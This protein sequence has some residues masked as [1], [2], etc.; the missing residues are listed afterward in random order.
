[1]SA[2]VEEIIKG[3]LVR[4]EKAFELLYKTY[5]RTLFGIALR[6]SRNREEAEDILQDAFIKIFHSI[7]S[8]SMQ[9]SFEGWLKRIVQNT[10]INNYRS[11]LK[12]D[13]HIDV[14]E[15]E[16][17]AD[18]S[19]N[20]IFTSFNAK[21]IVEIL[22]RLPEGYRIVVNL[23]CIDGYSH[24]EI[25]EILN[26]SISTSKSQLFKARAFLKNMIHSFHNQEAV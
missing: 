26:I 5:Y 6:Y 25:A 19:L 23:Y 3:C 8:F 22:N 7:D 16:D 15:K 1:M 4:D 10:A 14:S 13:L 11:N 17:I 20:D 12:F 21:D 9:G 2:N 18:E 24:K